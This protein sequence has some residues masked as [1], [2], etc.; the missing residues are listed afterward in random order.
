M[1]LSFLLKGPAKTKRSN[2]CATKRSKGIMV[3]VECIASASTNPLGA[4]PLGGF[5]L[6]WPLGGTGIRKTVLLVSCGGLKFWQKPPIQFWLAF[7]EN[8]VSF[9]WDEST[10]SNAGQKE[11]G[12]RFVGN[13]PTL[14]I[15][16][17]PLKFFA[18]SLVLLLTQS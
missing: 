15:R 13:D 3:L 11:R 16:I 5:V 10:E 6:Y 4:N 12:V 1:N 7:G 9:V 8:S 14:A 17:W 18:L 2:G